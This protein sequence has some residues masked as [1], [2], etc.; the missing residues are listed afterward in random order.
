MNTVRK[1][2]RNTTSEF[3]TSRIIMILHVASFYL[4][5]FT[6][7]ENGRGNRERCAEI[8]YGLLY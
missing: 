6:L 8:E 2:D 1:D 4:A 3:E 7:I 5:T